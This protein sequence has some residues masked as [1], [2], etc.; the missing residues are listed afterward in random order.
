MGSE[1]SLGVVVSEIATMFLNLVQWIVLHFGIHRP[2][3]CPTNEG[4]A[5]PITDHSP[6]LRD[7]SHQSTP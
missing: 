6:S 3:F 2:L 5:Q 1:L 4:K 7:Q